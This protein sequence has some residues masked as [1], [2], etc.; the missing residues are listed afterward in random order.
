MTS[1]VI[2]TR[3]LWL[4]IAVIAVIDLV[5]LRMSGMSVALAPA[6]A[7]MFVIVASLALVYVRFRPD[8]RIAELAIAC[9]QLIAFTAVAAV[10]SYLTVTSKFPL[11]DRQLAAIDAALY[12]DWPAYFSWVDKH[13]AIKSILDTAYDSC[14]AQ[15]AVLLVSLSACERFEQMREFVW[16]FMMAL[17]VAIP[18]S[19]IF[20]AVSAWV[21]FDVVARADAYHLADF[22]ALRAGQMTRIPLADVNGLITFPSFHTALAVILIY[23]S[24][25]MKLL[26]P[27]FLVLNLLVIASTPTIG[28]HYFIDVIAGAALVLCL[29]GLRRM[30]WRTLFAHRAAS[31][32]YQV[33][34]VRADQRRR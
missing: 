22:N 34:Y 3:A 13:P 2:E 4:V 8:R 18:I 31:P 1:Q 7:V 30:S 9:A 23:A 11:I 25:G 27:V 28:G 16:L 19:W 12:L 10:L 33:E 24:R 17:L 21:Q 14:L 5:W 15:T 26:F 32:S 20:P 6:K 29:I